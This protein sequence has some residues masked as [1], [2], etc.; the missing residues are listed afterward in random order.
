MKKPAILFCLL[1]LTGNIFASETADL[2]I[3]ITPA[4]VAVKESKGTS[5]LDDWNF[6]PGDA[7]RISVTPDTGFP[8]GIY[9]VDGDGFVDLPM[10]G[11]VQVT[12]VDKST[13]EKKVDSAYIPL[14]RYSSVQVRRVMSIGFQG[15][16]L[17]PGVYW[18]SPGA[19]L[20]QALSMSGGT[21]R[22]DGV[23]RLKWERSGK[24]IE[25]DLPS[26]LQE[27]KSITELGFK[28]GDIIRVVNRP[29]KTGWD[30]FKQEVLPLITLGLSSAMTAITLYDWY[31]GRR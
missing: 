25:Q 5:V 10:I 21:V 31:R 12:K 9:P 11:P 18:V 16:F 26:M 23:K 28:S 2:T 14:L 27:K 17:R 6:H 30:V 19:T 3:Q 13:F 24:K 7:I 4:P 20:W 22:S 8:N 1:F 15:G 29:E